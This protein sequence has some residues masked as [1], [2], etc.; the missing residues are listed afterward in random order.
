MYHTAGN[1]KNTALQ[2]D[3]GRQRLSRHACKA[4]NTT[5]AWR[6]LRLAEHNKQQLYRHVRQERPSSFTVRQR[7]IGKSFQITPM[8]DCL[9]FNIIIA[10]ITATKLLDITFCGYNKTRLL[11]K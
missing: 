9:A 5:A 11:Y 7:F 8:K 6:Q 10:K 2:C 3:R 4:F 1:K